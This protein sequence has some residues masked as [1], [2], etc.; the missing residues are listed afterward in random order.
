ME[1]YLVVGHDV[2]RVLDAPDEYRM[3]L[4]PAKFFPAILI[5]P[6]FAFPLYNTKTGYDSSRSVVGIHGCGRTLG[7]TGECGRYFSVYTLA[8]SR[9]LPEARRSIYIYF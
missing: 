2:D 9:G 8:K 1:T 7:R 3:F 4:S 5:F 6:S